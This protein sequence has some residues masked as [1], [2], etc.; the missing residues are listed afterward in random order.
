MI[1]DVGDGQAVFLNGSGEMA[2]LIRAHDW[3]TTPLG[4]ISGWPQSLKTTVQLILDSPFPNI[5][6]WGPE[7][8]QIYNA[9]YRTLMG[10][11]HPMGLGQPTQECWPE[12]WSINAPIYE[13]VWQGESVSYEDAL[14][15]LAR[16]GTPEDVRLTLA[17]SP[18]RDELGAVAG[19]LV[20]VFDTT[21]RF[22]A[23]SALRE[24]EE[25]QSFLLTFSDTLRPLTDPSEIQDVA[26]R[27][28]GQRL[29]A[30]R[31]Y[32]VDYDEAS[33][34]AT[35]DRD[36][37]S[38]GSASLAGRYGRDTFRSVI[39]RVSTG[40]VWVVDDI[41]ADKDLAQDERELLTTL[42][43]MAWIDVPLVKQGVLV[44]ILCV[45]H[46]AARHWTEGE[47]ALAK[48]FADR[49][50]VA[51]ERA[52][53]DEARSRSEVKY[54]N[55]FN[56]I[57][58]GFCMIEV[59]FDERGTA[60]DYRFIETN[61]VFEQQTGLDN[62]AGRTVRELAPGL[63]EFWFDI[64]GQ[65]AKTGQSLRFQHRADALGR[66][67]DVFAFRVDEPADNHVAVL[68]N[69]ITERSRR[70][71]HLAFLS[72]I[73]PDVEHSMSDADAM[74]LLG[75]RVG[76]HLNASFCSFS[77]VDE[78]MN[79]FEQSHTWRRDGAGSVLDDH[80][81][82]DYFTDEFV[83]DCLAGATVVIRDCNDDS[84]VNAAGM[85]SVQIRALVSTPV[86]R[87]GTWRF[88]LTVADRVP[89]TWHDDEI[90]LLRDLADRIWVRL[91][92]ARAEQGRERALDEAREAIRAREV[93]LSIASHELRTPVTSI[94]GIAQLL[95]RTHDRGRLT[96][97]RLHNQLAT[98]NRASTYLATLTNDLLDV[99]RIERG[100]VLLRPVEMDLAELLHD[101]L[102]ENEWTSH[103]IL[104]EVSGASFVAMLDP[105]RVRQVVV[106]VLDNA[107]KYSP[108]ADRVMV[109]LQH[110]GAG[111]RV[112]VEDF[113]I[114]L[115]SRFEED[116]FSPFQ[117]ASNAS[118][119]AIPGMGLG[120]YIAKRIMEQHGGRLEARSDG[121]GCGTIM[122]L[123]LPAQL[124]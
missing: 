2:A 78:P 19:V 80:L 64:Y 79:P 14:Y 77:V 54:R 59:L 73:G 105:N 43:H 71:S 110:D 101:I 21:D 45:T 122:S 75:S 118:A 51:I 112:D 11:K 102:R 61:T 56:S 69:D 34:Y 82:G 44:A 92:R 81:V 116:I 7:L 23:T 57:D 37:V 41:T 86:V 100:A 50:W 119:A 46:R 15:P 87:G 18:I 65:I 95:K 94:V 74:L 55:L 99:S 60:R 108:D 49:T 12:V 40:R 97:E 66:Y 124:A 93:F 90:E 120:L 58:E 123:W 106:N 67:Y 70:E 88:N 36:Y 25:Q 109:R 72:D 20:T 63:E 8:I 89:R 47:I 53:A 62:A 32:Y 33:G 96:E 13:R 31:T 35:V 85:A 103:R 111:Y 117:R 3:G 107:V 68:F 4:P 9:G 38:D 26:T 10:A 121:E 1:V 16:S 76:A 29:G 52:R 98:L 17:Y 27:L 113:G 24:L 104:V 84:R 22:L 30:S 6:L 28:L 83:R 48:E 91:E 42:E 39:D 114:G 115:P 5:A